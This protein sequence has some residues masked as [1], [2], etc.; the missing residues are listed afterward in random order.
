MTIN[1]NSLANLKPMKPGET[2][3]PGGKVKGTRDLLGRK[4]CEDL[5][6]HYS[7]H[8]KEA[9]QAVFAEDT[10]QYLKLVAAAGLP[11]QV[12]TAPGQ[13]VLDGLTPDQITALLSAVRVL[14]HLEARA[15]DAAGPAPVPGEPTP[16]H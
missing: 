2:R 15:G 11:T 7:E 6:A 14:E 8:G 1:P 9:I 12:E 13:S 4:F 5:L 16:L 3:N 10:T